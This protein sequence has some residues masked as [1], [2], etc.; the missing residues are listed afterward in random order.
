MRKIKIVAILLITSLFLVGFTKKTLEPNEVYRVYLEGKSLGLVESKEELE[1]YINDKQESIKEKYN[2][3]KVYV[4]K[5]LDIIK[6]IT[7]K[8]DILSIE[9]IYKKIENTSSFTIDGYTI[10]IE[11]L[12]YKSETGEE[13]KPDD[14][15]IYV[16]DKKVFE[17]SMENIVNSF[18]SE[19]DYQAYEE[20]NQP[21]ILETG[22]IVENIYIDNSVVIK[23]E[24]IPTDETIY[25]EETE[26]SKY[27][28]FGTTED[29]QLYSVQD[30]DTIADV[31]F[32]N[33]M[34]TDEFLVANPDFQNE[35]SLLYPGQEV[36]LGILNPQ[37]SIV[38]EN[39][40]VELQ[41][42]YYKTETRQDDTMY[43]GEKEII[44]TGANGTSLV[45]QKE[46][47]VN[48]KTHDIL[49]VST[50]EV[51]P[52]TTEIVVEGTKKKTTSSGFNGSYV[53]VPTAGDWAWP[54][55]CSSVSSYY[56]YRW[57]GFHD[58]IDIN[59]CGYGSPIYASQSGVV[60]ES[61]NRWPDGN[62]IVINHM[63]GYYTIYAHLSQRYV[64]VGATVSKG[65]V[66][67]GMGDTGNV[68]GVHVHFGTF[69][70]APYQ[71]GV[72]FD[73]MRLF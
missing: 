49:T 59:G 6:E 62:Y 56:G 7:Y 13:I 20:D 23:S 53:T 4:P 73:P 57:G 30:G 8:S 14:Q 67:G 65:Q 29:Q 17:N 3:D 52:T 68:T 54:A 5:D 48:G 33:K 46:K 15:K 43:E 11:G 19:A 32:N 24:K 44:Q 71:G 22:K 63:N 1:E 21:E 18:I 58:A 66:I 12:E 26:L 51:T 16:I 28:L 9:E 27:L 69:Q 10:S 42:T 61:S 41:E 37:V 47:I 35:N 25:M 45:A 31:A 70:G 55:N 50:E 40:V 60:T 36:T 64:S 34:S 2:V 39:H 72:H 38:Q